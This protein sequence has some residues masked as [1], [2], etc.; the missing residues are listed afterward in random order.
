MPSDRHIDTSGRSKVIR[1]TET[2]ISQEAIIVLATYGG[3]R[4][5]R[6]RV[7]CGCR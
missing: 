7:C 2:R 6:S 5:I 3:R 4:I 1:D